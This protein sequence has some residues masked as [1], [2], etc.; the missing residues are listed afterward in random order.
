MSGGEPIGHLYV[1]TAYH[2]PSGEVRAGRIEAMYIELAEKQIQTDDWPAGLHQVAICNM[3]DCSD[4]YQL[5]L[6]K[7]I[8]VEDV[9]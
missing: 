2:V 1:W 5:Q 4:G 7:V 6:T 8:E 3:L 9:H